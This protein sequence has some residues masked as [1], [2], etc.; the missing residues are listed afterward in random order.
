[1][2]APP[3]TQ[4]VVGARLGLHAEELPEEYPVG[5]DPQECFAKMDEDRGVEDTVG[6]EIE[7]LN[8]VIL[9]EPLEE[10]AR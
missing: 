6:I 3:T 7:V 1:M 10:V 9:Q 4:G 5:L 2:P 8:T